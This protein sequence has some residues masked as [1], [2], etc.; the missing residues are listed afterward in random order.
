MVLQLSADFCAVSSRGRQCDIIHYKSQKD[1]GGRY[2][3]CKILGT[4]LTGY[5]TEH[6]HLF[7][8]TVGKQLEECT[9][10]FIP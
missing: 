3:Y 6:F 8:V 4:L 7:S 1:S 5:I 10:Y 2:N 9:M